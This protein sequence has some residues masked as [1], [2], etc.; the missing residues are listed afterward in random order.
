MEADGDEG[1]VGVTS[2]VDSPVKVGGGEV[3]KCS[4]QGTHK[5]QIPG[6]PWNR[7]VCDLVQSEMGCF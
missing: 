3:T 4:W 6:L 2:D 5:T 7:D 1:R